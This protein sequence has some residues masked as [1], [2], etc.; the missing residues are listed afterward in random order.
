MD[1]MDARRRMLLN[2]PHINANSGDIVHFKTDMKAPLKECVVNFSPIQEGTGTPSLTNIRPIK[3][4]DDIYLI[5][6]GK[7]L[8]RPFTSGSSRGVTFTAMDDGSV[9][10]SGTKTSSGTVQ[11]TSF[12]NNGHYVESSI[13]GK[14]T[15]DFN[16]GVMLKFGGCWNPDGKKY[17]DIYP[18]DHTTNARPKQSSTSA[19]NAVGVYYDGDVAKAYLPANHIFR[20]ALRCNTLNVEYNDYVF[21]PWVYFD[22]EEDETFE[23]PMREEIDVPFGSIGTIY[24]GSLDLITGTLTT[25]Y[26][27]IEFDGTEHWSALGGVDSGDNRVY[28]LILPKWVLVDSNYRGCSHYPNATITTGTT[29]VGFQAY[30]SSTGEN[31]N[32]RFRPNLSEISSLE[33]WKNFLAEQK[34][35]GTPVQ[36]WWR[37]VEPVTYQ[38]TPQQILT[39]KGTNNIW[40]NAN[41]DIE[42]KYWTH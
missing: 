17:F 13:A 2:A 12:I 26:D 10:A 20:L 41:G 18:W 16:N 1:L 22:D 28:R 21:H 7:N 8:I 37:Y 5:R 39:L 24:G 27:F 4:F 6:C 14:T 38:L 3:G 25:D 40:S 34:A 29:Q 9:H 11:R 30:T 33:Q 32:L 23:K 36:C 42:I 31:K 35:A 19:E 15:T